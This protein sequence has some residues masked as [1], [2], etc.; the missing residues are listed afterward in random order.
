M[1]ETEK[2]IIG[3]IDSRRQ[4]IINFAN[5]IYRHAE[6]GYKE[7]RTSENS[8]KKCRSQ[9]FPFRRDLL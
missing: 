3:I 2:Q 6:L 8:R 9:V 5:D 7:F 1:D 4:E